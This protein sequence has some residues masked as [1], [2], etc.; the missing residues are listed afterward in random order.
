M[1]IKKLCALFLAL[2]IS[3]SIVISPA[4]AVYAMPVGLE[5]SDSAEEDSLSVST[6]TPGSAEKPGGG[7][8]TEPEEPGDTFTISSEEDLKNEEGVW[9]FPDAIL[10][11]RVFEAVKGQSGKDVYAVLDAFSG[12]VSA[13]YQGEGSLEKITNPEGLQYLRSAKRIDLSGNA[14]SDWTALESRGDDWYHGVTWD[15]SGNPVQKLPASFGGDLTIEL[16]AAVYQEDQEAK[17]LVLARGHDEAVLELARCLDSTGAPVQSQDVRVISGAANAGVKLDGDIAV[18]TGL[19][20]GKAMLSVTTKGAVR[21]L[22][23][24]KETVQP[25]SYQIPVEI[26]M[27]DRVSLSGP[28]K[29]SF[30][31]TLMDG[32]KA[33]A[34]AGYNLY[35]DGAKVK[36]G[37]KTDSKGRIVMSSLIPGEYQ[38]VQV[39]APKGYELN[40]TPIAFSLPEASLE[41]GK[42]SE[43]TLWDGETIRAEDGE[44]YVS[45]PEDEDVILRTTEKEGE[46]VLAFSVE[47]GDGKQEEYPS[48]SKMM[49]AINTRKVQ[50]TLGG[51]VDI[52]AKYNGAVKVTGQAEEI[53]V[54]ETPSPTP[55]P[56]PKPEETPKPVTPV[57][58]PPSNGNTGGGITNKPQATPTPSATPTPKPVSTPRPTETPAPTSGQVTISVEADNGTKEGFLFQITGNTSEKSG[59]HKEYKTD[60]T[61]SVTVSVPPGTYTVSPVDSNPNKGYELP[62]GQSFSLAAGENVKLQFEF[63]ATQRN[64]VLT[65]VDDDGLPLEDVTIGLFAGET[66]DPLPQEKPVQDTTDVSQEMKEYI[67]EQEEAERKANP[68]DKKNALLTGK[69]DEEGKVVLEDMPVTALLAVAINV[70]EGYTLEKIP[71]E[72]P[73]GLD[74][75]FEVLCEYIK[76]DL[77]IVNEKSKEL[78]TDVEAVLYNEDGEELANWLTDGRPHRLIR[79]PAGTYSMELFY[80]EKSQKISYEVTQEETLQEIELST[81]LEGSGETPVVFDETK[82]LL[83]VLIVLAGAALAGLAV[84]GVIWFRKYR[85]RSG[86]YQ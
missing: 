66:D 71:S 84:V 19:G 61:G 43:I 62:D 34:G 85:R 80:G 11:K 22:T 49:E 16:G 33:V 67:K 21:T 74:T 39:T 35:R 6:T 23:S 36:G 37:L 9:I 51:S 75:E 59:Y 3:A 55:T 27:Y 70:P 46:T 31:F 68:Y 77:N 17:R 83:I 2:G 15:V 42:Q 64:L 30:E 7:E 60:E 81:F 69:T 53:Q 41:G 73:A 65:V 76:V 40:P 5:S 45:G 20:T 63:T 4:M 29:G 10:R 14:I 44:V 1:K 86:G 82:P 50:G 38:L 54:P 58:T 72:I 47:W 56:T 28:E 13:S 26:L 32:G 79:V 57:P 12:Q 8:A 48:A 52:T 24:G 18:L 25:L 78:V